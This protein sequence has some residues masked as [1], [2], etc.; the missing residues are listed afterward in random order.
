MSSRTR[1]H[2]KSI[3]APT[4]HII[5]E[6]HHAAKLTEAKVRELRRLHYDVGVCI[7]CACLIVGCKKQTG[8]DAITFVTW[9]HVK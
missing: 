5:G 3:N 2:R 6:A 8:Y 1:Q 4:G 7:K 9:K